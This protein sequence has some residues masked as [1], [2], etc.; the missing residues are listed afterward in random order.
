MTY[1]NKDKENEEL[2]KKIALQEK[3]ITNLYSK[4][5]TL[6]QQMVGAFIPKFNIDQEVWVILKDNVDNFPRIIKDRIKEIRII[7]NRKIKYVL[8]N[9]ITDLIYPTEQ[10][11]KSALKELLKGNKLYG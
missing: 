9:Y 1:S 2:N 5:I 8:Y 10:K 3:T 7:K 11:A 4:Y 6:K